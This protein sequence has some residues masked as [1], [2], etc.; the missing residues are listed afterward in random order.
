MAATTG[1]WFS[2]GTPVSS[3]NKSDRHDI[4]WN[5]VESGFKH[6]KLKP[7]PL[8]NVYKNIY[9]GNCVFTQQKLSKSILSDGSLENVQKNPTW[10]WNKM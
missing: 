7:K 6:H 3:T 10:T 1:Q 9:L 4:Y 8:R 2:L 5:F